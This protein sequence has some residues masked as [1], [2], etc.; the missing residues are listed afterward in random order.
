MITEAYQKKW[1]V[2][3]ESMNLFLLSLFRLIK[4]YF[5]FLLIFR[6]GYFLIYKLIKISIFQFFSFFLE[7]MFNFLKRRKEM[8]A[9]GQYFDSPYSGSPYNASLYRDYPIYDRPHFDRRL[10][11]RRMMAHPNLSRNYLNKPTFEKLASGI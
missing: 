3:N 2:Q 8:N 9:P 4:N 6:I 10:H 5:K 7:I 11:A 1:I